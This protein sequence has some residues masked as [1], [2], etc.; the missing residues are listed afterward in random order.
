MEDVDPV[1]RGADAVLIDVVVTVTADVFSLVN[2]Q[3]LQSS[4][5]ITV[6]ISQSLSLLDHLSGILPSSNGGLIIL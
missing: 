6:T 3:A 4:S 1:E 5:Y 2:D